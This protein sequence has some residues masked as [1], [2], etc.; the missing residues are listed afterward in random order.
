MYLGKK[1]YF[2]VHSAS[3]QLTGKFQGGRL[4]SDELL[5][6]SQQEQI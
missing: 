3:H 6:L 5:I 4:Q 1:Y 2:P